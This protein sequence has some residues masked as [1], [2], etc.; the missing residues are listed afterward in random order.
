M[1]RL[2]KSKYLGRGLR[3][4]GRS[5]RRKSRDSSFGFKALG[6]FMIYF[7]LLLYLL[8]KKKSFLFKYII[9]CLKLNFGVSF[10]RFFSV[11]L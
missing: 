4:R 9:I 10:L 6:K 5:I 7:S 1:R 8:K 11:C 2:A 3:G